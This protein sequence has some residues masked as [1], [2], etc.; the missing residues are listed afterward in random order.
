MEK[1]VEIVE[2]CEFSTA[3]PANSNSDTPEK[4]GCTE[5]DRERKR[6][7][8]KIMLPREPVINRG[9]KGEKVGKTEKSTKANRLVRDGRPKYLC[10]FYKNASGMI[11]LP[12]EILIP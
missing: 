6:K 3:T 10:K 2:K 4:Q 7:I 9:K 12:L 11:F 1:P 5:A 8:M